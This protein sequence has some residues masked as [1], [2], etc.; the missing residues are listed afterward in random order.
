MIELLKFI[1]AIAILIVAFKLTIGCLKVVLWLFG[2]LL[3]FSA[4]AAI[5]I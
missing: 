2:I 5:L 1:F 4:F 3:L